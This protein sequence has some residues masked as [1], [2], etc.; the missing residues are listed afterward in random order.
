M[1]MLIDDIPLTDATDDNLEW[2]S[3]D[4]GESGDVKLL[5]LIE[6]LCLG[7]VELSPE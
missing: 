2:Y 6:I 3:S 1:G 4:C 5:L 7:I